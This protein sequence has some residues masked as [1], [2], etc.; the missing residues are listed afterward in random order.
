MNSSRKQR[1]NRAEFLAACRSRSTSHF[2]NMRRA[3][4]A[5]CKQTFLNNVCERFFQTY[6]VRAADTHG[7]VYT[8]QEVVDFICASAPACYSAHN[9]GAI[10][11]KSSTFRASEE[12]IL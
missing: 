11:R 7:I 8:P 3:F 2:W 10:L 12:S 1:L 5:A 4:G 6:S 9:S